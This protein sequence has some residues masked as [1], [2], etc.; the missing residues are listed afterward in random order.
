MNIPLK[1]KEQS[2]ANGQRLAL[3]ENKMGIERSVTFE[4][5][6][7]SSDQ[8]AIYFRK[9]G[10]KYNDTALVLHT[11]CIELYNIIFA[12]FKLG[13]K[14]M[15]VDPSSGLPF[16]ETC[17]ELERPHALITSSRGSLLPFVSTAV[18][19]IPMK[20]RT[21]LGLFGFKPIYL[22]SINLCNILNVD[23]S[24][25]EIDL[26]SV[27]G[28]LP[29]LITFTSGST[30]R[31][32]GIIRTHDFLLHQHKALEESLSLEEGAV[33]MTALPI[34]VLANLA[35]GM[36][37]IIPD[38][39]LRKP[40]KADGAKLLNQISQYKAQRIVAPPALLDCL[41]DYCIKHKYSANS[42]QKIYTGGG[43]VFPKLMRK[44]KS[45]ALHADIIAVYGSTE[46]EPIAHIALSQISPNDFEQI[47]S[48][49]GLLTGV[50]E[51]CVS[52]RIIKPLSITDQLQQFT[53]KEFDSITQSAKVAG[54]IVVTGD[55]VIKG[56]VRGQGDSQ[57]K[58]KVN[59]QVWHRTG[60][61]GYVDS[62][63]RLWLLGRES[64]KI[65]DQHGVLYPFQAEGAASEHPNV[66]RAACVSNKGKRTLV[67]QLH[68][69]FHRRQ[70]NGDQEIIKA[71]KNSLQ[72]LNI[73][74]IY[75]HKRIPVDRRHNSKVDYAA[76]I[77]SLQK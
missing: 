76:V 46:A 47:K 39:N 30:G 44:L 52:V 56:Y 21:G 25:N 16:M 59:N 58:F 27:Q 23:D 51:A 57:T 63:G 73:E 61:A 38:I 45:I 71:L 69:T 31:P 29:A 19:N 3:I 70:R 72:S 62:E 17:F 66:K 8:L 18:Q 68:D 32:K 34:F 10:I 2:H 55:H 65:V 26:N 67:I 4:Q 53:S 75:I 11:M 43:P 49:A 24:G 22:L 48:G 77:K 54:E 12:L 37:S 50:P 41:A 64:A 36:T 74:E 15:L 7:K 42:L 33:E 28:E 20:F 14:A 35:S 1:L 13:V 60:D 9:Q 5:L 40:G 6:D